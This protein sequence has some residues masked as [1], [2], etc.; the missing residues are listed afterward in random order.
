MVRMTVVRHHI[1]SWHFFY[2]TKPQPEIGWIKYRQWENILFKLMIIWHVKSFQIHILYH[3]DQVNNTNKI[4]NG[5]F[6]KIGSLKNTVFLVDAFQQ[7]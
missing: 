1:L 2:P 6:K 4:C 3:L 7:F 5:I